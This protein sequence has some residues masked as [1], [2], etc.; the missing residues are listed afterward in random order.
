MSLKQQAVEIHERNGRFPSEPAGLGRL[1]KPPCDVFEVLRSDQPTFPEYIAANRIPMREPG[2]DAVEQEHRIHERFE[3]LTA[4]ELA[5]GNFAGAYVIEDILACLEFCILVGPKKSL[6]TTLAL[7][8]A[9][10]IAIG[11]PVF[12]IFRVTELMRVGFF[13][14]ESGRGTLQD[15]FVRIAREMGRLPADFENLFFCFD[16]PRLDSQEDIKTLER[17]ITERQLKV[18]F[19]DCFYRMLGAAADDVANLFKMGTLLAAL[20]DLQRRT[21]CTIVLL[22][23]CPKHAPYAE[24]ELDNAAYAGSAEAARQWILLARRCAYDAE[25][26]GHH[27]LW[28][29][30]GGSMGHSELLALDIDEGSRKDPGG[31]RFDLEVIKAGEARAE[32]ATAGDEAKEARRVARK[33]EEVSSDREVILAQVQKTDQPETMTYF[34]DRC[35]LSGPRFGRA[36]A[37]LLDDDAVV[38]FG[39]IIKGNNQPLDGYCLKEKASEYRSRQAQSGSVS[40]GPDGAKV[41]AQATPT[42]VGL[43]TAAPVG[44]AQCA[45]SDRTPDDCPPRKRRRR[46]P[47]RK[48]G[49]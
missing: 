40:T 42:L 8:L 23:H 46:R 6:K 3:I 45:Q 34:R 32:A 18:V 24:P 29:S 11:K 31:R 2:E 15:A 30:V 26:P 22:H 39:T 19:L 25:Q 16:V 5:A 17:I 14:G 28:F 1:D 47:S 49:V 35:G 43:P 41:A 4:A 9:M 44:G 48:K 36:W 12:G 27:E 21:G 13:S 20:M 33:Q 10:C 7:Y 38:D 37:S